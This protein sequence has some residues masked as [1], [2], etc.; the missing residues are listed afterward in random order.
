MQSEKT[1]LSPAPFHFSSKMFTFFSQR[2]KKCVRFEIMGSE[3]SRMPAAPPWATHALSRL[4][5]SVR[6]HGG[7]ADLGKLSYA[8]H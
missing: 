1:T 3:V 8:G 6:Y 7:G 2:N 4:P 5:D